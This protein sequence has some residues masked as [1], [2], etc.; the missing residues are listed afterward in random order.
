ML[1]Y[2][3]N[4]HR[5]VRY[6]GQ[7]FR[8]AYTRNWVTVLTS[9]RLI[10]YVHVVEMLMFLQR[11]MIDMVMVH[12]LVYGVNVLDLL[13]LVRYVDHHLFAASV[14]ISTIQFA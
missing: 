10:M 5:N 13:H 11:S 2:I 8:D 12:R 4:F 14:M 7:E 3:R 9:G 1:W 6:V